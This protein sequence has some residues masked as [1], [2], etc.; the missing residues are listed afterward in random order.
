M[1]KAEANRFGE[2]AASATLRTEE[3]EKLKIY[4]QICVQRR[5]SVLVCIVLVFSTPEEYL[6]CT[7]HKTLPYVDH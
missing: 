6:R 7:K 3:A 4:T 1:W 2:T 5:T